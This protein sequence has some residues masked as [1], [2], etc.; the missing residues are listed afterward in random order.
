LKVMLSKHDVL[1][2]LSLF[3]T[4]ALFSPARFLLFAK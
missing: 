2:E 4:P 3:I 1:V